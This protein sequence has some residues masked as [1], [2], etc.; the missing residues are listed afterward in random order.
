MATVA[1]PQTPTRRTARRCPP[2]AAGSSSTRRR[3]HRRGED[4]A[5]AV[6]FAI[7]LPV[8]LMLLFGMIQYGFFFYSYQTGKSVA[9]RYLRQLTVGNCQDATQ[10]SNA[11]Y[12]AMAGATTASGTDPAVFN[13]TATYYKLPTSTTMS[14]TDSTLATTPPGVVGGAVTITIKYSTLN[15][16]IP[17]VPFLSN[18]TI[19]QSLTGRVEDTQS[20]GCS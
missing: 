15:M 18:S 8:L 5:S 2:A 17:L 6:E 11:V 3:R 9:D 4:G 12:A 20:Q 16:H 10:L 19:T 14:P 7:I 1:I 13:V